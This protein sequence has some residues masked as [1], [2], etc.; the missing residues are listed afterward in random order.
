M[1]T[2]GIHHDAFAGAQYLDMS[3]DEVMQFAADDVNEFEIAVPMAWAAIVGETGQR[4]A[5]CVD[6]QFGNV[7][8]NTLRQIRKHSDPLRWRRH[9]PSYVLEQQS[10]YYF[11]ITVAGS[12]INAQVSAYL[13]I[14]YKNIFQ[15]QRKIAKS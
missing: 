12:S 13:L 4:I 7:V 15:L 2:A 5:V 1:Q 11:D 3:V 8:V 10:I 14:Y 9:G 6:R